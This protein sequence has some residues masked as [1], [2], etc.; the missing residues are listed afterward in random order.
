MSK[1]CGM[2]NAWRQIVLESYPS[3]KNLIWNFCR[4]NSKCE[5][6]SKWVAELIDYNLNGGKFTRG[7]LLFG[8]FCR[9]FEKIYKKIAIG[10]KFFAEI[11]QN[12]PKGLWF[13]T[14]IISQKGF[15]IDFRSPN[16]IFPVP[17]RTMNLYPYP[18]AVEP[19]PKG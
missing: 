10:R 12:D 6:V 18:Y 7:Q 9:N 16:P 17:L 8:A 3:V 15:S 5:S 4:K 14:K 13:Y 2:A 1:F 11:L 19:R